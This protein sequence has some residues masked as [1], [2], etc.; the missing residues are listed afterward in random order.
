LSLDLFSHPRKRDELFTAQLKLL[1]ERIKK[2]D[3]Q[4]KM[5][6]EQRVLSLGG[7]QQTLLAMKALEER[8]VEAEATL[9]AKRSIRSSNF[10]TILMFQVKLKDYLK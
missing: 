1:E 5:E 7:D 8:L 9:A 4:R 10:I 2:A 3:D 6:V